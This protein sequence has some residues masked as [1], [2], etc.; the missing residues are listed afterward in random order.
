MD[1]GSLEN[2]INNANK[3]YKALE[4][5]KWKLESDYTKLRSEFHDAKKDYISQ[6]ETVN[7]NLIQTKSALNVFKIIIYNYIK[8]IYLSN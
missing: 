7:S 8:Y 4:K 1:K 6:L 5:Q 3:R 2:T